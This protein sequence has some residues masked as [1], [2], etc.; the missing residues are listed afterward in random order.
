MSPTSTVGMYVMMTDHTHQKVRRC[1]N[2]GK[3]K[4]TQNRK[5]SNFRDAYMK[6]NEDN[7]DVGRLAHHQEYFDKYQKAPVLHA[8]P[9][10]LSARTRNECESKLE[11][12]YHTAKN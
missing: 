4:N 12:L 1:F 2:L 6:Y 5:G 10:Q 3:I 11:A 8:P 9:E 7:A